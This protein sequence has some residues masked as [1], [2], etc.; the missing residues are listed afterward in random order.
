MTHEEIARILRSKVITYA[1]V[2]PDYRAQKEDLYRIRI[3]AGGNL[4]K[5]NIELTTRTADI[6]TSKILW[7]SVIGTKG[8]RYA[9]FD[10]KNFYLGTPL[11]EYEYMRM[12]FKLFPEHIIQ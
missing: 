2:V 3:T 5:C 10:I 8:A 11:D 6:L 9:G 4:I 1:R 12:P 7:K